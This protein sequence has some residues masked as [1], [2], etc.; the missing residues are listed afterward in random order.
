MTRTLRGSPILYQGHNNHEVLGYDQ[1][2]H[3][4]LWRDGILTK[5][6]GKEK[7]RVGVLCTGEVVDSLPACVRALDIAV[8]AL[9]KYGTEILEFAGTTPDQYEALKLAS[10]LLNADGC[11]TSL[12]FFRFDENSNMG[13]K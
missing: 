3:P 1:T 6:A 12:S 11:G 7:L 4:I 2:V 13:A 5:I 9:C 8:E 10:Q